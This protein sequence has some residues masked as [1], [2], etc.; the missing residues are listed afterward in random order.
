[1]SLS[2]KTNSEISTVFGKRAIESAI[3]A[4]FSFDFG[5]SKRP[6][7][8]NTNRNSNPRRAKQATDAARGE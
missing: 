4:E 2:L 7:K 3:F 1:M 5:G 8:Q 6:R